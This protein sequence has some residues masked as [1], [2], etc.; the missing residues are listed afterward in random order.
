MYVGF[1]VLIKGKKK[2][3]EKINHTEL[4]TLANVYKLKCHFSDV[5]GESGLNH[6]FAALAHFSL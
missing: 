5:R 2:V 6:F 1:A 3:C 4:V